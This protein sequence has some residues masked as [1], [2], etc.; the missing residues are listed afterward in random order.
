V[1]RFLLVIL[2]AA[3]PALASDITPASVV[4]AMNAYR[5]HH[6]L[7]LLREDLRL[8]AAAAD[9]MNDMEEMGYW[10]H[11]SP[12]GRS[13]FVWLA[14]HGYEIHYAGE[15]LA[16]GFETTDVL[17]AAWMESAGHRANILSPH[18]ED[19]GIAIID[20]LTTRRGPGKSIVVMFGAA[21]TPSMATR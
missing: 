7:P 6:H 18:F 3:A 12:D 8:D 14:A 2:L 16:S 21:R 5:A 19:C 10:A 4:A 15:N 13:P 17:V 20:G 1:K 11:Q 9:R